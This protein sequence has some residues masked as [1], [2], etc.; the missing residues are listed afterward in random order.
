MADALTARSCGLGV[1]FGVAGKEIGNP[2]EAFAEIVAEAHRAGL[3]L[4]AH[5]GETGGPESV[6]GALTALYA[7]HIGHGV[8]AIEDPHPIRQLVAAGVVRTVNT[9]DRRSSRST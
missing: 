8:R 7:Q 1:G 9:D 2:S 3:N 4:V 6:R 5:G